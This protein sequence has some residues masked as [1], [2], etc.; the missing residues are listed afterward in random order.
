VDKFASP[1]EFAD[2]V[3]ELMKNDEEYTKYVMDWRKE[4]RVCNIT[5]TIIIIVIQVIFLNGQ[6]HDVLERP[7]GF[8]RLCRLINQSPLPKKII[9][10]FH[11][12]WSTDAQCNR[13][14][15]GG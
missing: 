14:A 1:K 13:V 6:T 8:C 3:K 9:P 10:D 7:W 12:W 2:R 4:H 15:I 11:K 5:E